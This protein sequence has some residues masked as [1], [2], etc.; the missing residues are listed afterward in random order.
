MGF[1]PPELVFVRSVSFVGKK[2]R[3]EK[4]ELFSELQLVSLPCI[5]FTGKNCNDSTE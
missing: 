3:N 1:L 5:C 4:K 2:K